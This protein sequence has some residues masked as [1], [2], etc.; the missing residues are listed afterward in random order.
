[1]TDR[2]LQP[3][4]EHVSRIGEFVID[5]GH[6]LGL[7]LEPPGDRG[8]KG[9]ELVSPARLG[10]EGAASA[11]RDELLHAIAGAVVRVEAP[12]IREP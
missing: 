5:C 3:G 8:E 12:A 1:M 9:S 7:R 2:P 10:K 6:L 11:V 4:L